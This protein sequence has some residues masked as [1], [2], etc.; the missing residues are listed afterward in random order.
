MKFYLAEKCGIENLN[1]IDITIAMSH[2]H[3]VVIS[4]EGQSE[5]QELLIYARYG[6]KKLEFDQDELLRHCAI[7]MPTDQKRNMMNASS[8]FEI[9]KA[10]LNSLRA[11]IVCKV[12]SPGVQGNIG[13]YPFLLNGASATGYID[14]SVFNM[15][16][17][18]HANMKS[19][20]L[21]GIEDIVDGSLVYTDELIAN[22]RNRFDVE[23]PKR[24]VF[25]DI[26]TVAERLINE[27]INPAL[28]S[29]Y[30]K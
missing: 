4:K 7:S 25:A 3:D 2:F 9:I 22:V 8:N 24:V 30:T 16:D 14:E 19:I 12:H 23:L 1:E 11:K 15:P 5:G 28:K 21:D 26:D 10:L 27:I 18:F 17:M 13:G 6:D 20:Y 29:T